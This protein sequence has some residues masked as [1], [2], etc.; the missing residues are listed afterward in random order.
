MQMKDTNKC[1]AKTRRGTTCQRTPMENG[2]CS[3]H[4]G[5]SLQFVAHPNYKHGRYS[6]YSGIRE[7]EAAFR[8]KE[9][10]EARRWKRID[11]AIESFMIIHDREPTIDEMF[12]IIYANWGEPIL[13][14]NKTK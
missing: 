9:K 11:K 5:K 10:M 2:R 3:N 13:R 1:G 8:Q 12:N 14:T 7:A 4:G 6:K